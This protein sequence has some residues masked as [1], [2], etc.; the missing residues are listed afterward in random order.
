MRYDIEFHHLEQFVAVARTGNFTRAAAELNLSQSSLSRAV[1]KLED[2][3]GQPLFERKPREVVLT[4]HGEL[5]LER[6]KEILKLAE[7]TF[8]ALSEAGRHG[9]IRLGAIPT[10][11]PYFLPRFLSSFAKANPDVSVIV[12]EDTTENLVKRCS[13][14][15]IDLAILAMPIIAKYLE[16]EVL[17]DEELLLVV[18]A[19]HE[20]VS[21]DL[22]TPEAVE[23]FPFVTL[24][25]AHCLAD[26]IASYCRQQSVQPV[27]VERIS[28]LT[29]V[30]ELVA[31]GHGVSII[32]EMARQLDQSDRRVYRSFDAPEPMRT[33]AMLWNPYRY[34]SKWVKSMRDHLREFVSGE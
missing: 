31:L 12:Q 9:R 4:D 22:I 18:P 25:E 11:A 20:L 15:E 21:R 17:F 5:F 19:D 14:G 10:V 26:N 33:V 6:A 34:Q 32:P 30:Q 27:S 13:H 29:T 24:N 7:D 28:Q 1:Q 23:E 8:S 16:S 2:Q 3:I